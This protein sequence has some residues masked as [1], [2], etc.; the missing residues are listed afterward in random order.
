MRDGTRD[1]VLS[2]N[3]CAC[4][5]RGICFGMQ[6]TDGCLYLTKASYIKNTF[7]SYEN[8]RCFRVSL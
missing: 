2:Y 8:I 4:K 7:L 3:I 5:V 1:D 6:H